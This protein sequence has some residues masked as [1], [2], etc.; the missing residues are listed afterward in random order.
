V[1]TPPA[2]DGALTL[3]HLFTAAGLDPDDILVLRHT[4]TPT[5]L[6]S[7][8]D[9]TQDNV[10]QYVRRQGIT[11]KVGS[12]PERLWLNFL[13]DG[14]RRSRFLYAYDNHGEVV[15]ER[16]ADN[17]F[18]DLRPSPV[19]AALHDRLVVEWS[20]D[21]VNWAKRGPLAVAFPVVEIADPDVV[22]FPGFDHLVLTHDQ[23][24]EVME[25]RR[26]AHWRTA[27][28]SVQGIY[29][30]ADTHTGK[31]YVGKADGSERLL[32]R[33]RTYAANGHGGNVGLR[34]LG[35]I[36]PDH[37]RHFVY[38]ILRVFGPAATTPEVNDAEE[39]YKR[40][41]LTRHP[42]GLNRN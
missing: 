1:T 20:G 19:F 17:R 4:Y 22:P 35:A 32:G 27:L 34:E 42:H 31:L 9:V 33:W 21:A 25:D 23:L 14:A 41:L 30:I 2:P 26:Y 3:G 5:G 15:A 8:A 38:S 40:A 16:T 10:L 39:H 36:N 29:L 13:A 6:A 18:F 7:A 28:Q 12:N 11:N 37:R 24:L